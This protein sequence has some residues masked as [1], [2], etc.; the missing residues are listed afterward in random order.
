MIKIWLSFL[1]LGMVA[2]A[3]QTPLSPMSQYTS[4]TCRD[5]YEKSI[6]MSSNEQLDQVSDLFNRS[7]YSE[8][9]SFG[10][11]LRKYRRDKFYNVTA[12]ALEV[13]T[14]EG[15]MTDYVMESHERG[16]L[17]L[18]MALSYL[19]LGKENAA[20]VELRRGADEQRA[21]L[22]NYGQ[23]PILNLL[24]AAVWDRFDSSMSRPYW[25]F[26]SELGTDFE[27]LSQ[28]AR[29]RLVKIDLHPGEKVLW[30]IDGM[31][32]LPELDW[33]TDFIM[34]K[35]G[36]YRIEAKSQF[37]EACA[38]ETSLLMPTNSW[39]K[40]IAMKYKSEYHPW[41]YAKSL[42]RLP[43]GLGYGVVGV[44]SGAVVG[45]G[46]CGLS[47]KAGSNGSD[48]LCRASLYLAGWM[49]SKT[50]DLVSYTLKPDLRHWKKMPSAIFL[51][52]GVEPMG[53]KNC[54]E[55]Q[56]SLVLSVRLT[57]N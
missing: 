35:Q 46:G 42:A 32:T 49:I 48:E 56:A 45:L 15:S 3:T 25:K 30:S 5:V 4:E 39:L 40:K 16:Y 11:F 6:H 8:V 50:G 41:M 14:P 13:F 51:S 26:L 28:F 12:E 23:D 7:C 24:M 1:A 53:A 34:R 31:G 27:V 33:S 37:P 22:Y 10:N 18:L 38:S 29:N 52:S 55:E 43:V 57:P 19:H 44:T 21:E 20:L 2:C 54:S 47:A 36:P 17:T 9:I